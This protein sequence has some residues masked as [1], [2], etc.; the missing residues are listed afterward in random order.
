MR[1]QLLILISVATF[2][3]KMSQIAQPCGIKMEAHLD[4]VKFLLTILIR[5]QTLFRDVP[6]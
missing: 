2:H 5:I 1:Q 4:C 6:T 3:Y